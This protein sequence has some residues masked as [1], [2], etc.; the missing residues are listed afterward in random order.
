M[1]QPTQNDDDDQD[2]NKT[3]EYHFCF[4]IFFYSYN[5]CNNGRSK[6]D[7][8]LKMFS[9]ICFFYHFKRQ[10]LVT[11]Y[12]VKDREVRKYILAVY[13]RVMITRFPH[14]EKNIIGRECGNDEVSVECRKRL[15]PITNIHMHSRVNGTPRGSIVPFHYFISSEQP[16]NPLHLDNNIMSRVITTQSSFSHTY[17]KMRSGERRVV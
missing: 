2:C 7:A 9:L 4:V 12:S 5:D 16:T 3:K 1:K 8:V 17:L 11:L 6:Q 10:Y 13:L 14:G 15:Y